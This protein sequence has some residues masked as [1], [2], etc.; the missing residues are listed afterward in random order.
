MVFALVENGLNVPQLR[1]GT[2]EWGN[3]MVELKSCPFCGGK[4]TLEKCVSNR[5]KG[6]YFVQ[7]DNDSC[8]INPTTQPY[9]KHEAISMW[10]RRD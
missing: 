10:N 1:F 5:F 6:E 4:A 7:C 2:R 3:L 9:P 8:D